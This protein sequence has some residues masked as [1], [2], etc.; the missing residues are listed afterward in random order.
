MVVARPGRRPSTLDH[1]LVTFDVHAPRCDAEKG[2]V[3]GRDCGCAWEPWVAWHWHDAGPD[4]PDAVAV[5]FAELTRQPLD[6]AA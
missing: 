1:A 6:V 2:A 5:T 3:P 4:D